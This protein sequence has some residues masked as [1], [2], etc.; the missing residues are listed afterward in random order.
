MGLCDEA[1]TAAQEADRMSKYACF[2][3]IVIVLVTAGCASGGRG[4]ASAPPV[5]DAERGQVLFSQAII[6][7]TPGCGTCHS[8]EAGRGV[9]GPSLAGIATRAA[10]IIRSPSYPGKATSAEQFLRESITRPNAALATG[11]SHTV[12]PDWLT[13]LDRQE[14]EDLV[15]FLSTQK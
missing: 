10:A 4:L 7:S 2:L 11:Y 9:V 14:I 12:M 8:L 1:L 15:A 6:R 5:G 13:V 3:L